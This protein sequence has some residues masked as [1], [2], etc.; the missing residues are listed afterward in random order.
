MLNSSKYEDF[1]YWSLIQQSGR[2]LLLKKLLPFD[3]RV[4][5]G[6]R[7]VVHYVEQL[8]QQL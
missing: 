8:V 7:Y 4:V 1:L 3:Y 5:R 6:V 2:I